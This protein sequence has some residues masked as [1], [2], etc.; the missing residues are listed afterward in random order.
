MSIIELKNINFSFKNQ[1]I[2]EDANLIIDKP[3]FYC[4]VGK[5][6]C[7]KTTLFNILTKNKKIQSGEIKFVKDDLISYCD[8]NSSLFLNLSVHENLNLVSDNEEYLNELIKKFKI[9]KLIDASP[10]HLSEG[11][12]QRV[13]ITRTLLEDKEIMLLD[14]VTSHI[15]DKTASIILSY[16]KELSKTHIIIYATHCKKEVFKY[17]DYSIKIEDKKILLNEIN[18]ITN[19][20]EYKNNNNYYPKKL[21]NKVI[22]FKLDYVFL[23]LFSVLTA[24]SLIAVW[25]SIL[26]PNKAFLDVESYSKASQYSV[27]DD[28]SMNIFDPTNTTY[29][30]GTN[31]D[32]FSYQFVKKNSKFKL[33]IKLYTFW[34]T[35]E[36]NYQTQYYLFDNSLDDYEIRCNKN[37]YDELKERGIVTG[38]NFKF[39]NVNANIEVIDG[40]F[41]YDIF[42]T[43]EFTF[44]KINIYNSTSVQTTD[45]T[46]V[47]LISGRM[48]E[49]KDE[50]V[51][52]NSE[53]IFIENDTYTLDYSGISKTF[54]VVGIYDTITSSPYDT[55]PSVITT[56]DGRD[57]WLEAD[58]YELIYRGYIAYGNIKD[59][60]SDDVDYILSSNMFIINDMMEES[61]NTYTYFKSLGQTF[62]R[63]L[64]F[65]ITF[66]ILIV[67]YYISYWFN[68]NIYKYDELYRLNKIN[69]IKKKTII[70]KILMNVILFIFSIILFLIVRKYINEFLL[71]KCFTN[72]SIH[73]YNLTF[74]KNNI[75]FVLI[76]LILIIQT[77]VSTIQL[78][79]VLYDRT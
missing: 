4:L 71:S 30:L 2:F 15:D 7:G 63:I 33:G 66:D 70:S 61:Y 29:S 35:N 44:K 62:I 6:G 38:S 59:L 45:S 43:N 19:Q 11:E 37:C 25:L 28:Y 39:K 52:A 42:V 50:I 78:R 51:V 26:T 24:L 76:P 27:I 22:S 20:I 16:L 34:K 75:L 12:R 49:N 60:T 46:Q 36:D 32:D 5:N 14:E 55:Y 13:A 8:A 77:V 58:I 18:E 65:V 10:K 56:P 69:L 54:K 73:K 47:H 21:L 40:N 1:V 41:Y 17:A 67:S 23:I 72:Y 79:R 9:E 31:V 64:V 3:G 57:E 53:K 74:I 48:P 68:S